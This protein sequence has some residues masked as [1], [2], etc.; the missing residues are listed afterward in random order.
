V[1]HNSKTQDRTLAGYWTKVTNFTLLL[2]RKQTTQLPLILEGLFISQVGC[3]NGGPPA[4]SFISQIAADRHE[5][6]TS[7][8]RLDEN[9]ALLLSDFGSGAHGV[10]AQFCSLL[11]YTTKT[12][13]TDLEKINFILLCVRGF[14]TTDNI[15]QRQQN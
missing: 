10:R 14:Q 12:Q 13:I 4:G 5:S 3:G 8:H 9:E 6:Y 7:P 11:Q 15:T 1:N 2:T